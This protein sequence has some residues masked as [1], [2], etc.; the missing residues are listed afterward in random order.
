VITDLVQIQRLGES[1]RAENERLRRHLKRHPFA[2]RRIRRIAEDIYESFD[3]RTC[4]NCCKVATVRLA[5]RDVQTLAKYLG[6]TPL[7]F[8]RDF[9]ETTGD[10]MILRR[11]AGGCVFLSGNDCTVY[12]ARPG[13]CADFPHTVR[14]DGSFQSRMWDFSDRACYC[15]IVFETL[16]ALKRESG[17]R[18]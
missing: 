9:T 11:S 17:F 1:K 14:G 8:I 4:A 5:G 6:L 13:N 12:D 10:D 15:P 3:C 7:A 18:G 2:G 16:E